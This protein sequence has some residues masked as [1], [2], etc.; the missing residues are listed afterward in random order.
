MSPYCLSHVCHL[1]L[2]KTFFQCLLT[3]SL[4]STQNG[5][6]LSLPMSC[7]H[8]V[9]DSSPASWPPASCLFLPRCTAL[10]QTS[11]GSH[12]P[13]SPSLC[14]GPCE[15]EPWD[16]STTTPSFTSEN[17]LRVHSVLSSHT[18]TTTNL[19]GTPLLVPTWVAFTP[20]ITPLLS[21]S[22]HP[23]CMFSL[24]SFP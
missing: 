17:V 7:S 3:V 23:A 11:Y 22:L 8:L 13:I 15:W 18:S 19:E 1:T 10:C 2:Y 14:W 21:L 16:L 20:W 12:Q 5:T 4:P 24:F 9:Q 6:F